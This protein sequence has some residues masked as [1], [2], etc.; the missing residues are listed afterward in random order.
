MKKQLLTASVAA[1]LT[2]GS[3]SAI[4]AEAS[5]NVAFTT[6][7]RFRGI[8][9]TDKDFAVQ[10]GFDY[11][12]DSGFYIGTW[13]SNVDNFSPSPIDGTGGAQAELD[14]YGGYTRALTDNISFDISALYYYYPG[15]STA[16]DQADIDYAEYVPSITY[17]DDNLSATLSIAY[18]DDFYGETGDAFYYGA[19][20][21]FPLT[22]YLSLGAHAGYQTIDDNENW[23]TPDYTDW[24]ISL[25]TSMFGLDWSVA[26]IDTDLSD[27]ECFGGSDLCDATAVGTVSKSF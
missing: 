26:Y 10:G 22:D 11:A 13:A 16:N 12:W 14:F 5:A 6:D 9:Q 20:F 15:A 23:G 3:A 1:I 25:S 8:S 18:S 7:Y 2:M 17:S 24:S 4:A 19:D 27:S 21:E